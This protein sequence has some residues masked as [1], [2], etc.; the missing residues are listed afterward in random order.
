[1]HGLG[2]SIL[3]RPRRWRPLLRPNLPPRT[4]ARAHNRLEETSKRQ[5]GLRT[6]P[7]GFVDWELVVG[8]STLPAAAP[9]HLPHASP[10]L[11]LRFQ[12]V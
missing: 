4:G 2:A 8:F 6:P 1:M 3:G 9:M 10:L 5:H 11:Y 7:R 12:E